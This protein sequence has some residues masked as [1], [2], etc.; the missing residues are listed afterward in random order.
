M[1]STA[2]FCKIKQAKTKIKFIKREIKEFKEHFKNLEGYTIEIDQDSFINFTK[3]KDYTDLLKI[4]DQVKNLFQLLLKGKCTKKYV[5]KKINTITKY[6]DDCSFE[7]INIFYSP[8]ESNNPFNIKFPNICFFENGEKRDDL[9]YY[10]AKFKD[11]K[12]EVKSQD[13]MYY[14]KKYLTN[15]RYDK[16]RSYDLFSINRDIKEIK[17]KSDILCV[18]KKY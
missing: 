16:E 15:Y 10:I 4:E 9:N 18:L 6:L 5:N 2:K 3:E 17:E 1:S 8:F 13:F 14:L 7:E 11:E 12:L